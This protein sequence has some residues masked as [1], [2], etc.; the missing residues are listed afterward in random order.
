[1]VEGGELS[2]GDTVELDIDQ[3][4]T[5]RCTDCGRLRS[6]QRKGGELSE[7]D[8]VELDIDQVSTRRCTD[9]GRLRSPQRNGGR[10][11]AIRGRHCRAGHRPGKHATMYRLWKA[12]YSTAEWWKVESYQ[13]ETL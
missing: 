9:C 10:W 6:P 8:T 2:E 12:T 11:R 1:M 7:G 13:R 3:V 4:S 5:R